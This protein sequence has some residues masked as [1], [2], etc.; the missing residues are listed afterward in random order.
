MKKWSY[1]ILLILVTIATIGLMMIQVRWIRDAV[2]LKEAIFVKDVKQAITQVVYDLDKL[3]LEERIKN[4]RKFIEENQS[5]FQIYDSLN[6]VMFYNFQNISSQT[7]IDM[8]LHNSS[9]ANKLINDL[10]FGYNQK[11]PENF[12]HSKKALIESMLTY[13]LKN[14]DINTS[15]EFGIYSPATNSMIFQKTG[16]Y[17]EELLNDSFIFDLNP[18]GSLFS[19]PNKLLIFFPNEKKF[20]ISQLWI[21]LAVSVVL[22]LVIIISF[23]FSIYTIFRQKRLSIMKNDFINNMTHEFKTPISTIALACEALKDKDIQK[24]ES[25]YENYVGVIDEENGRLG[26]MS[27]QILQTAIIDKGQLKIQK[28]LNN[29]H[30]I[31]NA[32]MGSKTIAIENKGGKIEAQLRAQN[33]EVMG[34]NIHLTNVIINL[35]DNAIKYCLEKPDIVINTINSNKSL[36]I[37]IK[38]NGIGISNTNRKKIFEKLYRV[39]TGNVH[40]FKGFGLGLSYVKA[41]IDQHNGEVSVDSEMGKGST[42]TIKLPIKTN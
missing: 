35:L 16:K 7:D 8:I 9:M 13:E 4:R 40:N 5:S 29:I 23:S 36:L 33:D 37:R 26:L 15:F 24:T 17:P 30:D 41:I 21:L 25:L 1:Y 19:L 18:V 39:P 31:I 10:T 42:F 32:A 6:R 22:F 11:D 3:R 38:D 27:E 2:K 14:K 20:L 28:S 12:Y 34:D